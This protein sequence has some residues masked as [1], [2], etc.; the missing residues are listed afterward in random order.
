[1]SLLTYLILAVL[2]AISIAA[3]MV[4]LYNRL[5][6]LRN[7]A[8]AT[9]SQIRV[10]MKKRL[11]M[12][13]G[14]VA[15][16]EAYAHFEMEVLERITDLRAGLGEARP[17]DLDRIQGESQGLIG[18]IS[19][20]AE[21]YPDL[22]TSEAMAL[23]MNAIRDVEDE[24]AR[25]RYTY[26]NIVQEYNTMLDTFPSSIAASRAGMREEEYLSFEVDELASQG[27]L[28]WQEEPRR[29]EAG[30]R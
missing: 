9:L 12:V 13:E 3:Y 8:E 23:T 24:I 26:N 30:W 10:A 2:A 18:K 27:Y 29:P 4:G 7:G 14:L 16:T 25:Y 11:D 6:S 20:V 28:P 5:Q 17:K 1:M 15:S 19:A 21:S 22:K